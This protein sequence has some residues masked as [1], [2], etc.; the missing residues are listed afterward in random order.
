MEKKIIRKVRPII[1]CQRVGANEKKSRK[2]VKGAVT[3][4]NRITHSWGKSEY[5]SVTFAIPNV[6]F[7]V[8]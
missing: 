8:F 6:T 5:V 2:I 7:A 1:L 3:F 4:P